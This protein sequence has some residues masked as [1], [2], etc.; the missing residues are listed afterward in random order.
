MEAFKV[1]HQGH[2]SLF[3]ISNSPSK[4]SQKTSK[5]ICVEDTVVSS[6]LGLSDLT[7]ATMKTNQKG[8][9]VKRGFSGVYRHSIFLLKTER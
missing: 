5:G 9:K 8:C 2:T 3:N 6:V 4:I 7:A 1:S